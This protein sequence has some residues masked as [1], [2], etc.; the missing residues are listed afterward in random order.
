MFNIIYLSKAERL[1]Y[2]CGYCLAF[3]KHIIVINRNIKQMTKFKMGEQACYHCGKLLEVGYTD[4]Y[5]VCNKR[6][7]QY[8]LQQVNK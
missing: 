8:K 1:P 6:K 4:S 2:S 5:I 7:C 3:R